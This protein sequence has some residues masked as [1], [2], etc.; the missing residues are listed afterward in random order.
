[1]SRFESLEFDD[2]TKV[3][4]SSTGTPIRNAA[5]FRRLADRDFLNGRLEPALKNYS[6][7]LEQDNLV[8]PCWLGQVRILIELGEYKEADVWADKALE[9]FPEHPE[10]LAAKA[11]ACCRTG[12]LD[13]AM[14]YSDNAASGRG[15]TPYVWITRGEVLLRRR[16]KMAEHCFS[17]ALSAC[18]HREARGLV[19]LEISRLLRHHR[20]FTKALLHANEAVQLLPRY[21]V[22]WLELGRCQAALNLEDA[23]QSLQQAL[24]LNPRCAQARQILDDLRSQG[25]GARMKR[26]LRKIFRR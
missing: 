22:M 3:K 23:S 9:L 18:E 19:H 8:F 5:Y 14:A 26:S 16:S 15:V 11:I 2:P 12:L 4:S 6:K 10:L 20:R 25:L 21:A 24:E 7:A 17:Q 1:M 13:K